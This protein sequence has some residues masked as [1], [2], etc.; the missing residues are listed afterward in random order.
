MM[1]YFLVNGVDLRL[2][3][4]VMRLNSTIIEFLEK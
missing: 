4:A 3:F 1:I 2:D